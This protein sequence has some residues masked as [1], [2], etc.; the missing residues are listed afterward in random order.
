MS[1]LA[2][3]RPGIAE[4]STHIAARTAKHSMDRQASLTR[5]GEDTDRAPQFEWRVE[6]VVTG[7]VGGL[8]T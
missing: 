7:L 3:N 5:K 4:H 2:S 1:E 8:D 6:A